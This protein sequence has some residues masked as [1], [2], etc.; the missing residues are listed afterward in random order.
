MKARLRQAWRIASLVIVRVAGAGLAGVLAVYV[1]RTYGA[2]YSGNFF[3]L[4]STLTITSVL[5][6]LGAEPYLTSRVAAQ[7]G[8]GKHSPASYLV[9]TFI[10]V[11]ALVLAAGALLWATQ[12]IS[13]PI[14]EK[15]LGGLPIYQLL[16]AVLGLNSVWIVTG[17]CR[18]L[19]MA[20]V[21][22]FLETGL[23][24]LWLLGMLVL[25]SQTPVDPD[26]TTIALGLAL[27]APTL[28]LPILPILFK[29]RHGL[30]STRGIRDAARGVAS[31]GAVTVT[32][33]IIVLIPLQ[34]LGLYGMAHE[35][36]V[37]NAALRVSMFVGA[38]G[39]VIKSVIVRQQVS[40]SGTFSDRK[41]DIGRT[42]LIAIPWIVVS[43]VIAW[44]G[45]L[46]ADLFGPEFKAIESIILIMLI[47]QSV[48]VAGFLVETRAVLA[49]ERSLLNVTSIVTLVIAL[50]VT[51]PLV[52][53]Y[54]LQGAAWAFA[55]TIAV[56]RLLMI[57]LYV[58]RPAIPVA[59]ITAAEVDG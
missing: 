30:L 14:V 55:L 43:L 48:N 51:P 35:A 59:G 37:Y 21:S 40:A 2:E 36:G 45:D 27:M 7:A 52:H 3:Y 25:A 20:G 15:L 9:S 12:I 22:I 13:A 41:R 24:S 56:S 42:I 4:V 34:V 5:T 10:A 26:G 19:G 50:A 23:L 54:G 33:G 49:N 16:L 46:L 31:F 44:Q 57:W 11:G 1:A 53:F 18:A 28:F 39:V 6:R 17:Y 8:D 58:R 29:A 47:A 32:N 38:S